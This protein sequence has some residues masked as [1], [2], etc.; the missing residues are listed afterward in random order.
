M[1]TSPRAWMPR[2][3]FDTCSAACPM[4]S[5][6]HDLEKPEAL[7]TLSLTRPPLPHLL[8]SLP[9][10]SMPSNSPQSA[11]A[12]M[13]K[14]SFGHRCCSQCSKPPQPRPSVLPPSPH[15]FPPHAHVCTDQASSERCLCMPPPL[16]LGVRARRGYATSD[17]H[18]QSGA[19]LRVSA[20]LGESPRPLPGHPTC[21]SA[22]VVPLWP[23]VPRSHAVSAPR[24]IIG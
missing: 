11:N 5:P 19:P 18:G 3:L 2:A 14:Q 1:P 23:P 4:F 16:S 22:A 10:A 7:A 24:A 20:S 6:S 12:A 17:I 9:I 13:A 15:H 8:L 21:R